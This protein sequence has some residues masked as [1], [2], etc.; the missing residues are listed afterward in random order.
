[1]LLL[2]AS[3]P[4]IA[5][6]A[7]HRALLGLGDWKDA[8]RLGAHP[9][10]RNGDSLLATIP[11]L[12]LYHDGVDKEAET[13]LGV[14]PEAVVF[15]SKHR[16]ESGTPS[17]T[18]HPLGN[19]GKADL[20]GRA[21]ALV[22]TAPQRMT[23]TLRAVRRGTEG[24]GYAVTFEATHHGPF[25]TTPAFFIEAGST[26]REWEDVRAAGTLMRALLS[27]R[28]RHGPVAIGVGGGH[29]V[30]RLTDLALSRDVSLGHLVAGY[31]IPRLDDRMIDQLIACT[32]G[33]KL[34]YFHRKS[35]DRGTL[36]DL[37]SRFSAR[38]LESVHEGDLPALSD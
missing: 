26:E 19:F 9:V 6:M 22:P 32:P 3:A 34:V 27:A 7:Q 1:M 37:E 8:G 13:S 25:L 17:L 15:L 30:P 24:M 10:L 4:D 31:D 5:S 33:A 12:H 21:G 38:G 23:E 35:I 18:V 36:R 16:S 29:Y 28:P 2:V 20:G 14:R 11:D